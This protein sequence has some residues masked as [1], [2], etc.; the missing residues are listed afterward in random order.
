[1]G[2]WCQADEG[3]AQLSCLFSVGTRIATGN[4]T[5]EESEREYILSWTIVWHKKGGG[6]GEGLEQLIFGFWSQSFCYTVTLLIMNGRRSL[7]FINKTNFIQIVV[8]IL[9]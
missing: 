8:E 9:F 3:S 6:R 1:M 2:H 7:Y 5:L 4:Q